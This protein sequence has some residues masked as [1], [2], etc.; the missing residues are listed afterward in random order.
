MNA[1]LR[2]SLSIN[3]D[4]LYNHAWSRFKVFM[5]NLLGKIY[6][7]A[8][9]KYVAMYVT[10]LHNQNLKVTSIRSHLSAIAYHHKIR[11]HRN[12]TNTFAIKRLLAAYT[13]YDGPPKQRKG[14]G[15]Q[16][17]QRIL[18]SITKSEKDK[19][20]AILLRAIFTTMYH[21]ALRISEVCT[22]PYS[23]HALQN[24][25]VSVKKKQNKK[26]L[27]ISFRSSKH[28]KGPSKLEICTSD[29]KS[30]PIKPLENY[31]KF[32]GHSSGPFFRH[33]NKTP[34]TSNF[35]VTALKT[36]LLRAHHN[37]D[38]YNCHSFR[39]GKATDMARSGYSTEQIAIAGRWKTNAFKKYIK[40]D[41]I[42][43]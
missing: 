36:H 23:K 9:P 20:I 14:I 32:R 10:H 13:K 34:I 6:I 27:K 43:C 16:L 38:H 19:Y 29:K 25:S 21:A 11:G 28:S 31:M 2:K 24:R 40:P 41:I 26:I 18:K 12:P 15:E 8:H 1:D 17:L 37:P 30:C 39:I 7:P 4:R 35:L 3:A 42:H 33:R 22:M 5:L